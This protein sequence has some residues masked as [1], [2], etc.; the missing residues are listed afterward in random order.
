MLAW[1]VEV[2]RKDRLL[3]LLATISVG[4][5]K[6]DQFHRDQAV[7]CWLCICYTLALSNQKET[8]KT[9]FLEFKALNTNS[10]MVKYSP[11]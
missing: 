9:V 4:I 8:V 3:R 1:K 5:E 10:K 11:Y 6:S 2:G 7:S